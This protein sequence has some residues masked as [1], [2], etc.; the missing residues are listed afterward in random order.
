MSTSSKDLPKNLILR[1]GVYYVRIKIRGH[2]YW[3]STGYGEGALKSAIQ[4]A[5]EIKVKLRRGLDGFDKP[6]RREVPTF[7]SWV[8]TYK[9]VYSKDKLA[10]WRDDQILAFPAQ[11]WKR[12]PLDEITQSMAKRLLQKRGETCAGA[13]INRERGT[14]QA[15]FQRA[16]EEGLIGENP[17]RYIDKEPEGPRIR[18]LTVENEVKLRAVLTPQYNRWLTFMLG[19]GLRLAEA[20]A[21]TIAEVDHE[22][23]LIKV[24]DYAAKFRKARE[25]PLRPDVWKAIQDQM[26]EE[27]KLWHCNQSRYR[28][29]LGG[30]DTKRTFTTTSG[31][32]KT[33]VAS[34]ACERAGIPKI[35]PHDLRHSFA[36]RYL[37]AGGDIYKLS[38]ILGHASVTM[39]EN[40]YAHLEGAD[41]VT[42]SEAVWEKQGV[43]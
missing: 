40:F 17:F 13:T 27:G 23:K 31:E 18:L 30:K 35:S 14:I 39:T 1:K 29:L 15:V 6:K 28:N 36:T 42:A 43:A 3:R 22:K 16:I 26:A 38:K 25:V 8:E 10:G 34:N 19:T 32:E 2:A 9:E 41:L 12:I 7:G 37:Q 4:K 20:Q 21:I 33:L 24:P 5:D 11:E